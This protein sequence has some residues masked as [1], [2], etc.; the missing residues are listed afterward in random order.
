MRIAF[1]G[2]KGGTGKTTTAIAVAAELQTRGKRVLLVDADPQGSSRTWAAVAAEGDHPAPTVVAMDATMHRPGQLDAL[3]KGYD[4]VIID[5]PPRHGDVMKSALVVADVAVLPC[6]PSA[7]DAWALAEALEVVSQARKVR[8]KLKAC[9]LITRKMEN[10]AV[11]KGSRE[12]LAS[13][14]LPV[15]AAELHYLV[16]YQ[17]APAAGL[18]VTAY[19]PSSAAADEV[20]ALTDELLSFNRKGVA[21]DAKRKAKGRAA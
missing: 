6:G 17:E 16:A 4:V 1:A 2:Q 3:A 5:C 7:M 10:T 9:V 14:G 20:R 13:S 11:G 12:V 18:G 21:K 19:A 8:P 15:L